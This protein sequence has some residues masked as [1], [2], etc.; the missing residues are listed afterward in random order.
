MEEPVYVPDTEEMLLLKQFV[1]P[2]LKQNNSQ[3][4][5]VNMAFDLLKQVLYRMFGNTNIATLIARSTSINESVI[6]SKHVTAAVKDAEWSTSTQYTIFKVVKNILK[7]TA[8]DKH[9]IN[10]ITIS[11]P[12]KRYCPI[13]GKNYSNRDDSD[14]GKKRLLNWISI[15]RNK[16][17]NKSVLGIRNMIYFYTNHCLPVFQLDIDDWSENSKDI[18][19][20]LITKDSILTIC[21]TANYNK[22]ILWL[23][24][25]I[26]LILEIQEEEFDISLF[27]L[28]H[29]ET[30]FDMDNSDKH[31]IP[32]NELEILYAESKKNTRD[33]LIFLLCLTTGL[34]VAGVSRIK[35]EHVAI[36][37][38]KDIKVNKVGR[39]IEKGNK[40]FTFVLH[41]RVKELIYRWI[42]RERPA[43]ES[44]YLF[45]GY[46]G[47]SDHINTATIRHAF[48]Q[49]CKACNLS[50]AHLH[51]HALRHSYAHIL[52]ETGNSVNV[53]SKLLGHANTSTTE[54]FYLKE[55]ASD[56]AKRANIPWLQKDM[57]PERV[58]PNFL[59]KSESSTK[60]QNES[61]Q[62]RKRR[63]MMA[64]IDMFKDKL[65]T[66]TE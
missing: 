39:T 45:P 19:I 6:F 35:L 31:R 49:V 48:N 30:L 42:L 58:V 47:A 50:G 17:K 25:F 60:T 20:P 2:I 36:I 18:A 65:P 16:T 24:H 52:L 59:G 46:S 28:Q 11:Q 56:V 23:K 15:I 13:L 57:Q 61:R 41:P 44:V 10:K 53:V 27:A 40:W 22:K 21:G 4:G 37:N 29:K 43:Y 14:S 3:E 26:M 66:V 63:K 1:C 38:D 64:K 34:R 9:F 12:K 33:E 51:P 5:H 54:K 7:E 32:V 8:A 62:R 55:N